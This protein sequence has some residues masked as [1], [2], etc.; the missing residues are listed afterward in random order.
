[1]KL[2]DEDAVLTDDRRVERDVVVDADPDE[3]WDALTDEDRLEEW[4]GLE[5]ELDPVE[6][7]EVSVRDDDG[8]RT[9]TVETVTDGE[10]LA[11]TWVRPEQGPSLV[12]FTIEAV[13]AGTRVVVVE[14]SLVP[15]E[16]FAP[17][18]SAT[19]GAALPRLRRSLLLVF[20]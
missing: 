6:G 16:A 11:F 7:G 5:V 3:V 19:W 20:A 15:G 18:A 12:E 9:G 13:P 2:H 10:H 14:T 1:M 17:T 8:E 4:L